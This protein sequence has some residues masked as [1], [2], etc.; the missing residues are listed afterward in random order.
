MKNIDFEPRWRNIIQVDDHPW[1]R[2]HKVHGNNVYPMTRFLVMAM[3]AIVQQSAMH[4]ISIGK[5]DLDVAITCMLAISDGS[6]IETM[7]TLRPGRNETPE[8][9]TDDWHEFR[10]FS[11]SEGR[12]WDQHC[13]GFIKAQENKE[14]NP[15]GGYLRQVAYTTQTAQQIS[16]IRNACTVNVDVEM[17]YS[18]ILTSGVDYGPVF[19]GLTKI[20]INNDHQA[21]AK[22]HVP[23]TKVYIPY[24]YETKC[25]IHPAT[26]DMCCQ[27]EWVL[28]GHT[29][30][31]SNV[32]FMPSRVKNISISLCRLAPLSM[33]SHISPPSYLLA[34]LSPLASS[35]LYPMTPE[36]RQ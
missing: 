21:M 1:I 36:M 22:I 18:N 16:E 28:R 23:N 33:F 13:H 12:G 3:E 34:S 11:W 27:M 10:I 2:Q 19:R 30:S 24:E 7:L 15:V 31:G 26:L 32:T 17:L 14:V 9:S 6:T 25:T 20:A 35:S 8:K 5:I 4:N 29:K